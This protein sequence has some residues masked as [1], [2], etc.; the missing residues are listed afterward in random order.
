[1]KQYLALQLKISA[2][3]QSPLH[4][5]TFPEN[6][7]HAASA[8]VSASQCDC[9]CPMLYIC[10]GGGPLANTIHPLPDL[11][12]CM[13][14]WRW[15]PLAC[16]ASQNECVS[17]FPCLG[18]TR[19]AREFTNLIESV[20]HSLHY[21]PFYPVHAPSTPSTT[22]VPCAMDVVSPYPLAAGWLAHSA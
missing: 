14:W 19:V 21:P 6:Q 1:M 22:R 5:R 20:F 7:M 11:A 12:W 17:M 10:I 8:V 18:F 2:L 3:F 4:T 15:C 9:H 16:S 13:V